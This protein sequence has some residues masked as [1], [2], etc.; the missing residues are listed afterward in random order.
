MVGAF[1]F[2]LDLSDILWLPPVQ[3]YY[4]AH[5]VFGSGLSAP[6]HILELLELCLSSFIVN[7]MHEFGVLP[8]FCSVQ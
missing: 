2:L 5:S 7:V 3:I 8:S 1:F 6:A 4:C